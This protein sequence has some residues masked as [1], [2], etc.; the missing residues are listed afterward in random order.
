MKPTSSQ[1]LRLRL[2]LTIKSVPYTYS[3]LI[4]YLDKIVEMNVDDREGVNH[5]QH[6]SRQHVG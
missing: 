6:N 4:E 5:A 1:S 3:I 2:L